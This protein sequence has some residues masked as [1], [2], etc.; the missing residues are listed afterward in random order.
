MFWKESHEEEKI[1][2]ESYEMCIRSSMH[3]IGSVMLEK[4]INADIADDSAKSISCNQGHE[5][6]FKEFRCKNLLTVLGSIKVNRAYYY[7]KD[8]KSGYCPKDR[9]LHIEG[10][11][12][13]PGVR[14]MIGR[15]GTLRSFGL[16]KNDL[17]AIAG[18]CVTS[19]EVERVCHNLGQIEEKYYWQEVNSLLSDKVIPLES[20][21]LLYILMDGTGIPVVPKETENRKGKNSEQGKTREA[22]LGCV[23]TQTTFDEKG[24]P[25][26]DADSTTYVGAIENAEQFGLRIYSEAR[27]RGLQN[28]KRI[29]VI[30]DGA[31][32]IWNLADEH[33]YGATQIIDLYHA[34]EHYW[35]VAK[36]A[37]AEDKNKMRKWA[38]NR[39]NELDKGNVEHV[40]EAIKRL[41]ASTEYQKEVFEREGGYFTKNKERMRYATF[42]KQ[43]YFVGSGVVE[44]GCK[45]VIGQRLKQS[46]MRWTVQ[47]AN[48]II[49]LRCC[50]MS[51]QWED[52]WEFCANI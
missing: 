5:Y 36:V 6:S 18:V 49:A 37:F 10:T 4:L 15:V 19:K 52:L 14:R 51:N 46:G 12:F 38:Q 21:P 8:C 40:I 27:R 31:P 20:V 43:G 48:S 44:A 3:S 50:F 34:R 45:A 2:L 47:G 33:F 7:D 32:W 23:F 29:C 22:K 13:S 41:S 26:R 1:D 17:E 11:S 24:H 25:V 28:A 39:R 9:A 42:K 35:N 16:S 30:G